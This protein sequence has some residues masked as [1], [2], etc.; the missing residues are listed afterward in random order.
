MANVFI[1]EQYMEDIGDAI[2]N[3]TGKSDLIYPENMSEEI[4][5]IGADANAT[6]S[7]VTKG[8]KAYVDGKLVTGTLPEIDSIVAPAGLVTT[9]SDNSSINFIGAEAISEDT[10]FRNNGVI[11]GIVCLQLPTSKWD[12]LGDAT[13]GDVAS[14]KTFTSAS[15]LK[16]SGELQEG[17]P[18][19]V[20]NSIKNNTTLSKGSVTVDGIPVACITMTGTSENDVLCRAGTSYKLHARP[21]DFG[22]A[23]QSDVVSGK[24]FTSSEGIQVAGTLQTGSPSLNE[25]TVS[26]V[27]GSEIKIGRSYQIPGN[28]VYIS[29]AAPKKR[30]LYS[31]AKNSNGKIVLSNPLNTSGSNSSEQLANYSSY[32]YFYGDFGDG[33]Y[34]GEVYK[35]SSITQEVSTYLTTWKYSWSHQYI[36]KDIYITSKNT[37]DVLVKN[38]TSIEMYKDISNFG[39]LEPGYAPVGSTFTSSSGL[40]IEGTGTQLLTVKSGTNS[41]NGATSIDTGLYKIN[42]FILYSTSA[43]VS[44]TGLKELLCAN[45]D[46]NTLSHYSYCSAYTSSSSYTMKYVNNDSSLISINGG[47]VTFNGSNG[48]ALNAST[49]WMAIG[50]IA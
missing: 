42:Y 48:T 40:K 50:Y 29:T 25:A 21:S 4:L 12:K 35:Y 38:G 45:G 17:A 8:V 3:R 11:P 9:E 24:T 33:T 19:S 31:T 16:V 37:S 10:I 1:E 41:T 34:D 22:N 36:D 39:N 20:F 46:S 5:S 2:R 28:G 23:K 47:V 13:L 26:C 32:P 43:S 27:T 18:T 7:D 49:S 14:G 6:S 15:G 30:V 44:G